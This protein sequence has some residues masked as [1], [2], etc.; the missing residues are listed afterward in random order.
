[1]IEFFD[2]TDA[3]APGALSRAAGFGAPTASKVAFACIALGPDAGC[4]AP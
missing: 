2:L 1:M 3:P 4:L